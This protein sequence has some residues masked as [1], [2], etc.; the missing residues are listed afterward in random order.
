MYV[1]EEGE[2]QVVVF[3]HGW[4]GSSASFSFVASAFR[5]TY[6]VLRPDLPGFGESPAP[7]SAWSAFDYA[8]AVKRELDRRL[9]RRAVFV[10]H[11]FGG[12]VG[13]ALAVRYPELV[14]ALVLTD[15]AGIRPRLTLARKRAIARYRRD[16]KRGRRS[17]CG[18]TDYR[19]ASPALRPTFVRIVNEDLTD[20]LGKIVCPTLLVWGRT[21]T[22][23][24]PA[25]AKR[26]RR[27]ITDSGLVFLE[28]GHF[29]YVEQADTYVRVLD[30]FL[31]EVYA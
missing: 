20:D 25:M 22:D 27:R 19:E 18:S 26:M 14:R 21:D 31:S 7:D 2:G 5:R 30:R 23:T 24:P 4:G 1:V 6:R 17:E 3:L 29:A 12:R 16:K 9:V 13:I 15:S 8:D 10:C 11:S 28:G